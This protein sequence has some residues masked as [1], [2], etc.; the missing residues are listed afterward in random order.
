MAIEA[1]G[2]PYTVLRPNNFFQ[3]DYW[4][5]DALLQYNV[6][7]QPIGDKGLS[8]VDV[9]DIAE[10]AAITLT[11]D[12][13]EG[14]TYNLVGPEVLTGEKT[15][16]MWGEALGQQIIYAGNDLDA[17]E[18]QFLQYLP[19]SVVFDFKLMYQAF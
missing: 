9:A 1:S 7:P 17:W 16:E 15:A 14:K 6:Y 18:Q 13:H 19:A 4:F 3:N 5:K 2:I 11:A 12:G 10:A 8:R